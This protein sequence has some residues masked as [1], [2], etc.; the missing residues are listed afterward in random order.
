MKQALLQALDLDEAWGID[1]ETY[2]EGPSGYSLKNPQISTTEYVID[3]RFKAHLVSVQ[4]HSWKKPKVMTPEQFVAWAKTINWK[5]AGMLAH[6]T[7][8][9]GFIC[10]HHYGIKAAVYFDTMSMARPLLPIHVGGGLDAIHKA[11]GGVGKEGA[12]ALVDIMGVRDPTPAQ[13]KALAKYA[14]HDIEKTWWIFNKM[15]DYLPVDELKLINRTIRMYVDPT[16]LIDKEAID[17][18]RRNDVANK[19]KLVKKLN[20][21]KTFEEACARLVS[22]D[23]F[24]DLLREAGVEPP[25]KVSAKKSEKAGYEVTTWAMSKQDQEFVDLESHEDRRVRELMSA[26]FAV[27]SKQME[28]RC[29]RLSARAHIGAQPVYLNYYGARP[30]RWSG[31]DLVN[32]QNLSSKRKEGGAELRASVYAPAGYVLLIADLAQIEARLNAWDSRQLDK[33]ELFRE[34][35]DVYRHGAANIYNKPVVKITDGE[36]F[37]GKTC[38]LALGY[39]AG[40][41]RFARTLRIGAFGPAVDIT[42]A[43]AK[44]IHTAWRNTNKFIVQNWKTTQN[45][46]RS[47]VLGCQR[48]EHGVM[49]YEGTR[50]GVAFQHGP[51]GMGIRYDRVRFDDDGLSYTSEYF[52]GKKGGIRED[53]TRLYGGIL[54]QNKLE[55]LGR[56]LIADQMLELCDYLPDARVVMS[57]HDELVL[58]VP[59]RQGNKALKAAKQIMSTPPYWAPDLPLA[60]DAHIS[61]R[62]D[63]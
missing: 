22:N 23:Q 29:T 25:V 4:R 32:W 15:V 16:V 17:K 56:R 44:D 20:L 14:G 38:D 21:G 63:K 43:L 35:K 24:A 18:V 39:Q 58:A 46:F 45:N 31:G 36:R 55:H 34:G 51:G 1:W 53:R 19:K 57:T 54:V 50:A 28:S 49:A 41:P 59:T 47:A 11:F 62:Y 33:L 12:E 10:S 2:Y 27:K 6:H 61:D 13:L 3:E 8:F 37:I 9:D 42:D 48:I 60:V 7:Q 52:V 30:G 26:R 40:A 5:R